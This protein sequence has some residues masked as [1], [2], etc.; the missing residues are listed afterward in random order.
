MKSFCGV[1]LTVCSLTLCAAEEKLMKLD[2]VLNVIRTNMTDISPEE[3][4]NSAAVGLIKEMGT[5]VQLVSEGGTNTTQAVEYPDPISK[6][7]VYEGRFGYLRVKSVDE[8][9]TNDFRRILSNLLSNKV[10][11]IVL[12]LRFAGGTNYESAAIVADEFVGAGEPLLKLG[13]RQLLGEGRATDVQKPLAVLVNPETKAAAE[14][15]AGILRES[16][17]ALVIGGRTAGEARLYE[18]FTLSSG[19]KLRV[20]KVPV[21]VG[22][23]KTLPSAGIVP[24][25]EVKISAEEEMAFYQDPYRERR[26]L[27]S[28]TNAVPAFAQGRAVNEAELVRRHRNG[29]I[30]G[31]EMEEGERRADPEVTV[32]TD[33]TLARGL[34]FLKGISIWKPRR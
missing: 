30:E 14:A 32:I 24:D 7:T 16:A 2:E 29:F 22:R 20:G 3:L 23:G 8:R 21:Q 25:I 6:T 9:L 19:Q 18:I 33:P 26:L 5:K 11:G 34:D 10:E 4:D 28:G 1:F 15:L 17:A 13:E 12:D 31:E 27:G